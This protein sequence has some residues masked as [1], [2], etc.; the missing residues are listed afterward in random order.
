MYTYMLIITG[1]YITLTSQVNELQPKVV[2]VG[3]M[4]QIVPMTIVDNTTITSPLASIAPTAI[5]PAPATPVEKL[6]A[7]KSTD[8]LALERRA[9][10]EKRRLEREQRRKEKEK[11]RREKEKRKQLKNKLKT[12]N[13]IKVCNMIYRDNNVRVIVCND[14]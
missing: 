5:P 11:K 7:P 4:L 1:H 10:K 8:Q 6:V 9:E 14:K 13:M 12:E 2:Q 3:N